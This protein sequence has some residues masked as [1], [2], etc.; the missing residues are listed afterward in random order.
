MKWTLRVIQGLLAV[1]FIMFGVMKLIGSP[2]QVEAFRDVYQ[3]GVGFMYVTGAIE[4]LAAVGLIAGFWRKQLGVGAS[5]VLSLVMLG[6]IL[7]H[8]VAG[9]GFGVAATPLI[10]LILNLVLLW[11]LRKQ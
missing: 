10:L 1:G 7:T 6:A 9:Q 5:A 11:G 4:L 8:L 2:D 3:Y